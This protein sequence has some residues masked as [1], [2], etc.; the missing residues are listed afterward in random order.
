MQQPIHGA[1]D[2]AELQ[3]R[4]L[5]AS[6]IDDFSSNV[7]PLGTPSFIREALATVDLAHYPDRQS[8]ALRAALAK[9]HCC[10]LE[11]LLI[12]NG[13]N[14]LIHLIARALLQPNDPVL[15]I[16]P[17]FGEY[18]YAS[19]L[20]GAQLLRYQA[21]SETGF[22]IDIVACCHLIKQHRPRLVWL[23]NPNNPTG[24]Y[25]D[26]E[27]IAQLQAACTTVQAYLVLDLAYADLV[28]GDWGLGIGDWG[29]GESNS[30]RRQDGR[31]SGNGGRLT[32]PQLPA[33]DNHHQ[34]IYLYSLTKSYALAGLRLG[35]VVAEQA[36]IARLQRWQPQWSVNSL[37]QA[38]GLAI[39]QHPH[40]LAQQ[41]E[42]WW[43]WSEQLRQ[44]LSQL[45]LKVLPSCLPFF[46]VE[47]ANAQQ[48]RS[49]LLNHACLVRDCSSFGLPQ[50]VRIAPR[51][52]AANQRL[53]NA[54]RSLC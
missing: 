28:V 39:C 54:W 44:G 52:P 2:Y 48:T 19:S 11:Q 23:C 51:Q 16:E 4:G 53:L 15:L 31:E 3:Q 17:T 30:S 18:A 34:I 36:V 26:A 1:I 22:A 5:V 7:N 10:E 40:W 14:E 8:L 29:L 38:A 20:A 50:F 42:Q 46:L 9:R 12:G 6:Q 43:I 32:S 13:S 33:P 47:V 21:T 27:A 37:A 41:L 45:S 35:Y 24:S 25:L 49:A